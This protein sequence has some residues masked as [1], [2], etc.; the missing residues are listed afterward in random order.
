MALNPAYVQQTTRAL[1]FCVG[2]VYAQGDLIS[3]IVGF[4]GATAE[5]YVLADG[6]WESNLYLSVSP[7]DFY[8]TDGEVIAGTTVNSKFT[9]GDDYS[10]SLYYHFHGGSYATKGLPNIQIGSGPDQGV[11]MWTRYFPSVT[12]TLAYSGLAY[13][14]VRRIIS[15]LNYTGD[16]GATSKTPMNPVG[17]YRS[18]KCR[19]FDS[20]GN[21]TGYGFTVNP[22]WQMIETVLRYQIKRQQPGLSGLTA[23]EKACFDWPAMVDHAARNAALLSNG[24]PTYAGNFAFAA[25]ASL[26]TMM[27]TQL[28]NCR[29]YK[30]VRGS[31]IAFIGDDPRTTVFTFSQKLLVPGSV[32]I[33]KK[34]L[35]TSPNVYVPQYRDLGIPAVTEIANVI[36]TASS[37]GGV[38]GFLNSFETVGPQ[39]FYSGDVFTYSGGSDD[40]DFAGD[41]AVRAYTI[42]VDGLDTATAPPNQTQFYTT[43]GPQKV[44]T[45]SGGYVGTQQ[46]RFSQ[47][48]PTVVQHRAHQR[49]IGQI[50][51]GITPLPRATPVQYDLGNNTFEQ[52]NR[53]MQFMIAR[54][55]GVDGANWIAPFKGSVSGWLEAIDANGGALLEVEEGDFIALDNT[56]TAD[57]PGTYEVMEITRNPAKYD[58]S[59]ATIDLVVQSPPPVFPSVSYPPGDS[60]QTL[61][62]SLLPM[63]DAPGILLGKTATNATGVTVPFWVM[64]A[65]PIIVAGTGST[66][67]V[68]VSDLSIWWQGQTAPTIYP[69]I[70]LTGMPATVATLT[71]YLLVT[72]MGVTPTM[73]FDATN[74]EIPLPLRRVTLFCSTGRLSTLASR[75]PW[76][77]APPLWE[78]QQSLLTRPA[79]RSPGPAERC[80]ETVV[81]QA[82]R[83]GAGVGTRNDL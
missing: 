67:A 1:P 5:L 41:Y 3:S 7:T 39:P 52:T 8:S 64:Q 73:R 47:R 83:V 36:S 23:A 71:I 9:A 72:S 35:S 10:R 80:K 66:S 65:T 13:Y 27:E 26:A 58:G 22:T 25:D 46:S 43:S 81:I 57:F 12:P 14:M 17:V 49:A 16:V 29:S 15:Q 20:N 45:A 31:Q 48:A 21:V 54:D 77:P 32:Q 4:D 24:A 68:S 56:A 18:L 70:T 37:N 62:N 75:N 51:P 60:Y 44:A 2:Y 40:A 59:G 30:R 19:M 76:A 28:R 79:Q 11:E 74:A 38:S 6:E 69:E 50:A 33:S 42:V 34:D 78:A 61:P 55:L 82:V 63:A 53:I